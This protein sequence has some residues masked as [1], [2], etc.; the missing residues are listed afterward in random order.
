[1]LA[2][3]SIII[4]H[5]CHCYFVFI[6]D[7]TGMDWREELDERDRAAENLEKKLDDLEDPL[8]KTIHSVSCIVA[9]KGQRIT[10][11]TLI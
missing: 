2:R 11:E 9:E 8:G 6:G 5:I 7:F 3:D 4:C 10:L 1:M